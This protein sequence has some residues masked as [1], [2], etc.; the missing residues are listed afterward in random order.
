MHQIIKQY[1]K[2]GQVLGVKS[3]DIAG[4][5]PTMAEPKQQTVTVKAPEP[6]QV[7]APAVRDEAWINADEALR[8]HGLHRN[9]STVARLMGKRKGVVIAMVHA[10]RPAPS[11]KVKEPVVKEP[12]G[13]TVMEATKRALSSKKYLTFKEVFDAVRAQDLIRPAYSKTVRV[14]VNTM[15]RTGL[16]KKRREDSQLTGYKLVG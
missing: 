6:Q 2:L 15:I 1:I 5:F 4:Q 11:P 16:A 8:L 7:I 14:H 10:A 12:K 9:W 3:E 13:I